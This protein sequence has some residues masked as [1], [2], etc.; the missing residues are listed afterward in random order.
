VLTNLFSTFI[1]SSFLCFPPLSSSTSSSI[2]LHPSIYTRSSPW[3]FYYLSIF[4]SFLPTNVSNTTFV[5]Y[6]QVLLLSLRVSA[7]GSRLLSVSYHQP[8]ARFDWSLTIDLTRFNLLTPTSA[9]AFVIV[10]HTLALTW[11]VSQGTI[12]RHLIFI[13]SLPCHCSDSCC[14]HYNVL[15]PTSNC[16]YTFFF[17]CAFTFPFALRVV[18]DCVPSLI[19]SCIRP[20]LHLNQQSISIDIDLYHLDFTKEIT[21]QNIS[22]RLPSRVWYLL[23]HD[24]VESNKNRILHIQP[25]RRLCI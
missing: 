15:L 8:H 11:I 1:L 18:T 22:L 2:G 23:H 10:R 17:L 13:S 21:Y 9:P 6:S 14:L 19:L 24:R 25:L 16:T 20:S 12:T 4:S 5:P 7:R 3:F